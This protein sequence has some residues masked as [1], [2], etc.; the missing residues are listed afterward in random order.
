MGVVVGTGMGVLVQVGVTV[1][2]GVGVE[3][4]WRMAATGPTDHDAREAAA[5]RQL[6]ARA[7]PSM[8]KTSFLR[9]AR[10]S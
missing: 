6:N 2:M 9:R 5:K 3:V 4:G 10:W 7:A 8:V 1:G